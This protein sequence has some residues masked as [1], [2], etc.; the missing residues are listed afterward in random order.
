MLLDKIEAKYCNYSLI[1]KAIPERSPAAKKRIHDIKQLLVK[2]HPDKISGDRSEYE[3]LIGE[4]LKLQEEEQVS[5]ADKLPVIVERQ[6][7]PASPITGRI[8]G[9]WAYNGK[10]DV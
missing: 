5:I 8:W 4:L 6:V 3:K 9:D 10:Y 2:Y 7:M 1:S